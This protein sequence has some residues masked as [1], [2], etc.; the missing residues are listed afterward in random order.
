MAGT[1]TIEIRIYQKLIGVLL[2]P[3]FFIVIYSEELEVFVIDFE[4]GSGFQVRLRSEVIFRI[5]RTDYI[6]FSRAGLQLRSLLIIGPFDVSTVT[7]M[8]VI[9]FR[10]F[11]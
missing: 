2:E 5:I 9:V 7:V 6:A 11:I 10:N 4:V 8:R 3:G 1:F